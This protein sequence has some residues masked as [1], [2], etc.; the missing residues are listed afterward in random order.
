L[1]E[2]FRNTRSIISPFQGPDLLRFDNVSR[3]VLKT[4]FQFVGQQ[5][6]REKPVQSLATALRAAN[7]NSARPMPQLD[8]RS[9]Q[10]MLLKV[11]FR[12]TKGDQPFAQGFRLFL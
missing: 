4:S 3:L 8:C 2:A 6:A 10:E 11:T 1:G 9:P 5:P 7:T 12:T